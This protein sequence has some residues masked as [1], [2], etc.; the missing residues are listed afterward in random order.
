MVPVFLAATGLAGLWWF[1]PPTL[2]AVL[3]CGALAPWYARGMRAER[4]RVAARKADALHLPERPGALAVLL[5]VVVLRSFASVGVTAFLPFFYMNVLH[6]SVG[7]AMTFTFVYMLAG[8]I[9]TLAGG[10][11]SDRIGTRRLMI[12]SLLA[13]APLL[14]LLPH[15]RGALAVMV[16]IALG[17]IIFSPFSA[18]VVLAQR[19][20][21]RRIG[22]ASGLNIGLAIGAGGLAAAFLGQ[23]ADRFGVPVVLEGLV[24]VPLAASALALALPRD[25]AAPVP[26]PAGRAAE[27]ESAAVNAPDSGPG[28]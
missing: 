4:E 26:T 12:W 28:L 24:L 9:G 23:I 17:I 2:V 22:L 16:L 8:G 18:A 20:L 27:R 5:G 14:A 3:V 7:A 25:L 11:L 10:L 13:S 15:V 6:F 1:V 19:C 21:P